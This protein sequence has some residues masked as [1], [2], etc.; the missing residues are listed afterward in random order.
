M[1]VTPMPDMARLGRFWT[2]LEQV[3]GFGKVV[4][5]QPS[6]NGAELEFTLDV[7]KDK[8]SLAQLISGMPGMEFQPVGPDRVA[9]RL[10]DT[11]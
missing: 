3:V 9:V 1:V 11:W 10:P 6:A 4:A 8:V 5:T 2:A 7:G